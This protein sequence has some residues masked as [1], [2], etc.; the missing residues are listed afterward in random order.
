M[1]YSK[2]TALFLCRFPRNA[3][4]TEGKGTGSELKP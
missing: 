4:A 1:E 2:T 3:E